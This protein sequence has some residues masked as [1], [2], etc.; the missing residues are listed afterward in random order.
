MEVELKLFLPRHSIAALRRHPLIAACP[1][2]GPPALLE[3]V[4]YDTPAL[5][6]KAARVGLRTR[7]QGERWLQTVKSASTS[8][9]GLSSRPEWEQPY[10]GAFDFS[11]VDD[12]RVRQLLQRSVDALVPVFSTHFRRET[13][14]H[15]PK[16]GIEIHLMLDIGEIA[17]G[18]RTESLCELELELVRGEALDL[19]QFALRL[20]A[21]L[22]LLPDDRSKAER[23]YRLHLNTPLQPV[24]AHA[25][26]IS[27][28]MS[29]LSAF[30]ELAS[31]CMRQW[32]ANVTGALNNDTT[33]FLYPLCAS[34]DRLRSL[35]RIFADVLPPEFVTDWPARLTAHAKDIGA[36][37][38]LDAFAEKVLP[39]VVAAELAPA[40]TLKPLCTRLANARATAHR[41]V[42]NTFDFAAQGRRLL[43]FSEALFKLP[44]HEHPHPDLSNLAATQLENLRIRAQPLHHTALDCALSDRQALRIA[45]QQLRHGVE[46]FIP[47]MPADAA[48]RYLQ[49]LDRIQGPLD[50]LQSFD[51]VHPLLTEWAQDDPALMPGVACVN[52]WHASHH[53]HMLERASDAATALLAHDQ[54]PWARLCTHSMPD[55]SN[56]PPR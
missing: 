34:L 28:S 9:A 23:G 19:L 48:D 24:H 43:A 7:R 42:G 31:S 26:A 6:L 36:T 38:D 39:A 3:N 4:Y 32:Q 11:K 41:E 47:L 18:E 14:R 29:P 22:P 25:S 10:R 21:D 50:T 45:V 33:E 5:T 1:Q 30:R 37:R 53:A 2:I 40:D 17:A 20:S 44:E 52:R 49:T 35:I 12:E 13:R 55:V 51:D 16:S 54:T 27:A 8:T 56:T 15:T 46:F